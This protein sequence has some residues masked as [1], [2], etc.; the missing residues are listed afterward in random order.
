MP[1]G[2]RLPAASSD[3]FHKWESGLRIQVCSVGLK[4]PKSFNC[5]R[6]ELGSEADKEMAA[7]IL[8]NGID[9]L[10]YPCP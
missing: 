5:Q 2:P 7:G 9:S 8:Q 6:Q 3:C 1:A 4:D 10:Q